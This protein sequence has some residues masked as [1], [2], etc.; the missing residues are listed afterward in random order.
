MFMERHHR[1]DPAGP[2]S[3]VTCSFLLSGIQFPDDIQLTM[4]SEL[5]WSFSENGSAF[6]CSFYCYCIVIATYIT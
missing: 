6:Y 3:L 1:S 4:L 5:N 2:E